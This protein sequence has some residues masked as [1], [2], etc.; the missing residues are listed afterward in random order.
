MSPDL[1]NLPPPP[2]PTSRR[3]GQP[4][5]PPIDPDKPIR[6]DPPPPDPPPSVFPQPLA[7]HVGPTASDIHEYRRAVA[8]RARR[9][10]EAIRLFEP[11]PAQREFLECTART[12][13]LR[14]SNRSGKTLT[15]AY[16][17]AMA[18]TG[19]DPWGRYPKQDGRAYIIGFDEKHLGEIMYRKLFRSGPF[20]ILRDTDTGIW[21]AFRPWTR[22]DRDRETE[23][24]PAPALIP[25]RYVKAISWKSKADNVPEKIKF[26]TG[27]ELDFFSSHGK[28]PRGSDLDLVW[29]DEEIADGEWYI[30]MSARLLDRKGRMMWGATPQTGTDQLYELHL[31]CEKEYEDWRREGRDPARAPGAR[32][33]VALLRDNPHVDE[34]QKRQLAADANEQQHAV[35]IEGGFAIESS[36]IYPEFSPRVHGLPYFDIPPDWTRYAVVDPGRQVCAVLFAAV[37]APESQLVIGLGDDDEPIR[38]RVNGHDYVLLYDELYITNCDAGMFGER[39]AQKCGGQDFEAFVIDRHGSAI[40][41]IGSGKTVEEQYSRALEAHGIESNA[42]KH[43]FVWGSDDVEGG[44]ELVRGLLR[45][46]SHG[47]PTILCVALD[48]RLP[49]FKWEIE[50]YRYKRIKGL[51]TDKPE[52][53]GRVH[54]MADLRYLAAYGPRWVAPTRRKRKKSDAFSVFK[55]REAKRRKR[56]GGSAVNL[57]PPGSK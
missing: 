24:K 21:R 12:R 20:K 10:I 48:D 11:L 2:K 57:G 39:M 3:G 53:R 52:D 26:T 32:E 22:E 46:R 13:L 45:V 42:T 15:P 30:E 36:K 23:A 9:D 38:E 50:R 6:P 35:R 1:S 5:S 49:N 14:G 29:I 40:S 44:V 28:P 27:W 47:R 55:A 41:D 51:P 17:M 43:G 7:S 37:P 19:R 8:E 31:R 54:L 4:K 18:L 25:T 56:D 16:E 33:F 34:E